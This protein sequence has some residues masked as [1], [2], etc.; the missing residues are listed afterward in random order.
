MESEDS[1][2]VRLAF[3][4]SIAL[5]QVCKAQIGSNNNDKLFSLRVILRLASEVDN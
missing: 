1:I 5:F 2:S 4:E 3:Y